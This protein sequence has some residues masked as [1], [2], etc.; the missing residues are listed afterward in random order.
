VS[1]R[2]SITSYLPTLGRVVRNADQTREK[3]LLA[4]TAEFAAHGAAGAR[5]D[6]IAE[7]AGVN[8]RMIY[9]YFG[10]KEQLFETVL[11]HSLV[12]LVEA[13]PLETDDLPGYAGRLFDYLVD[14]PERHRLALWR[15]LEG[16]PP[17]EAEVRSTAGK[18]ATLSAA[19]A[20]DKAL[21]AAALLVFIMALVQAWPSTYGALARP[22]FADA[23]AQRASVVEAVRRLTTP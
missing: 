20:H 6:R 1:D 7:R 18:L 5:I 15:T 22:T 12:Q 17:T 13:V 9:A 3:L 16:S 21:D 14:H 23:A 10:N 2:L 8:K 19:R 4:A 11:E